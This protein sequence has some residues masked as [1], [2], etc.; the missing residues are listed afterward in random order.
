MFY[1]VYSL[2]VFD[3]YI[4]QRYSTFN[5]YNNS[6]QDIHYLLIPYKMFTSR[7]PENFYSN[8]D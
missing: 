6:E 1:S 7:Q 8:S 4:K 5:M 2:L 3:A